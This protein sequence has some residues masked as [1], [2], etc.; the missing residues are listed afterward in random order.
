MS[1]VERAFVLWACAA[2]TVAAQQLA[3]VSCDASY[4]APCSRTNSEFLAREVARDFGEQLA[5]GV[6]SDDV[7]AQ[8]TAGDYNINSGFY[9]FVFDGATSVVLAHGERGGLVGQSLPSVFTTLKMQYSDPELLHARFV[10]AAS[11]TNGQWVQYLWPTTRT[12]DGEELATG[13]EA[14][15]VGMMREDGSTLL[16]LGVGFADTPLPPELPCSDKYDSFCAMNNVRSLVGK[17]QTLLSKAEPQ[18]NFEEALLQL[19]YAEDDFQLPGGFYIFTY[20]FQGP[21]VSHAK[22][23]E[24]FGQTLSQIFVANELGTSDDGAQLHQA[25]IAAA[26]GAGDGWVRYEWRDSPDEDTYTK[27]ALVAKVQFNTESYYVGAGFNF[28]MESAIP[29]E[30]EEV[31]S[32]QSADAVAK[33]GALGE[34]CSDR[35]NLPCSV[36]NTLQLSSHALVRSTAA[37]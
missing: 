9:P 17:A 4:N 14:F 25:F 16:C 1:G 28:A 10:A 34:D 30:S 31:Q 18:A 27:I 24:S 35:Y 19:S 21:L 12:Q 3:R 11:T 33:L 32:S 36:V 2:T 13:K 22:L 23:H 5:A 15:V 29:D 37:P 20:S 8:I 26:E 7:L 6:S